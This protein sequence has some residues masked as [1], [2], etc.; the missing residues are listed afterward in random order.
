MIEPF[1][2]DDLVMGHAAG[3]LPEPVALAVATHLA[4][5][6]QSRPLYRWCETVGGVLLDAIEPEPLTSDSWDRM[7]SRLGEA[8]EP[9]L[10]APPADPRI[11]VPLRAYVSGSLEQL[12]WRNLG[13]AAEAELPVAAAGFRTSLLR[14]RAGK[15]V[16]Q[17]THEG[18]ELT[19]V[20][21][22]AF[23]D[24]VGRYRRGDLAIADPALDH[25]PIAEEG[26]D[27]LCLAVTDA[28]L[29]LTGRLGRLLNPFLR[30]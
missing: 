26:V 5:S 25:R 12:R 10:S 4:L 21:E 18:H 22:G 30:I 23:S 14:V 15:A 1:T 17:H 19:V 27:C 29:R 8:I 7:A 9:P 28:P 24:G 13:N 20:L 16:P 11:P 2:L 6:P 3:T